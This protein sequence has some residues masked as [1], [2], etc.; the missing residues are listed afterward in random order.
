MISGLCSTAQRSLD[1]RPQDRVEHPSE[2]KATGEPNRHEFPVTCLLS[3]NCGAY[4]PAVI[5]IKPE[6]NAWLMSEESANAS[7]NEL[8]AIEWQFFLEEATR[9][10]AELQLQM[11]G[12]EVS[13]LE[14]GVVDQSTKAIRRSSH[15]LFAYLEETMALQTSTKAPR[16]SG[17]RLREPRSILCAVCDDIDRLCMRASFTGACILE[18]S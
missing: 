14:A 15:E 2:L 5:G 13:L 3:K 7:G 8:S 9:S 10:M 4:L 12:R 18:I 11:V 16:I 6:R 17:I 1:Y